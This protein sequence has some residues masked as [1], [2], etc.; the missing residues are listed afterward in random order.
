MSAQLNRVV[1]TGMGMISPLGVTLSESWERLKAGESGLGPITRFDASNFPSR[2]VGEVK[3]FDPSTYIEKKELK[4]TDPFVQ[5]AIAASQM[6]FDDSGLDLDSMPKDEVGVLIGSGIGGLETIERNH[7]LLV[8]KGYR[9]IS[10]FFI[11]MAV[12]N[13]AASMVS[14]RFGLQGP[15]SSVVTACATGSNAIG[16][17][18]KIVQRGDAKVMIA[19]GTE[20]VIT[21]LAVGGFSVMRA[22]STSYNDDPKRASRPFDKNRDGFVMS[23]GCALLVLEELEHARAR[24][25]NI[26]GEVVGYGMSGDACHITMPDPQGNGAF[27]CM[28]AALKDAGLSTDDVDYINAH[29]T[30]TPLNDK[31]ET[32]AIKRLFGERAYEIPVS[33]NKSMVGHLLGA[34]GAVEAAFTLMSLREGVIPPTI[35]YETPDPECDLDYVPNEKR[36]API[37]VA[38]SNSFGFGGVNVTLAFRKWEE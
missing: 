35:N 23:E 25:A 8:Q 7:T 18:F 28:R 19:G 33:S 34:A 5:L 26:Y 9:R 14:I 12:I 11:P 21:P 32:L 31:T 24:G 27:F 16:D 38:I 4:R 6:A 22:L 30:S 29:G 1:V 36:E 17:A 15:H 37:R 20:S 3:G 10:P 2:V 13:M